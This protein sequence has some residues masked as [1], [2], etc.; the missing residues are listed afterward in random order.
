MKVRIILG[1]SEFIANFLTSI[2]PK[3]LT[4][5][6]SETSADFVEFILIDF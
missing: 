3:S 4:V 5:D 1:Y 2:E 6:I